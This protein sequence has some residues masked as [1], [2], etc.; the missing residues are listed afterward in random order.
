MLVSNTSNWG[1]CL[2]ISK[3]LGP[4][5]LDPAFERFKKR[6]SWRSNSAGLRI[7]SVK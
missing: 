4:N 7:V 6:F 3:S 5:C 1:E 2:L